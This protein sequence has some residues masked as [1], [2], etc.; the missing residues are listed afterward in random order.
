MRQNTVM[1]FAVVFAIAGVLAGCG[2]S[3]EDKVSATPATT[4]PSPIAVPQRVAA[5]EEFTVEADDSTS[6]RKKDVGTAG[7]NSD[8]KWVL[9]G[10]TEDDNTEPY[11][12]STDELTLPANINANAQTMSF[13]F[14]S[15]T[16][17]DEYEVCFTVS[18]VSDLDSV[19]T[20]CRVITV[21]GK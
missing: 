18:D 11:A 10:V 6:L 14:D 19:E 13:R 21:T 9:F 4:P 20:E 3:G 12:T 7:E 16:T 17:P 2:S 15:N 5:G 8:E 1:T